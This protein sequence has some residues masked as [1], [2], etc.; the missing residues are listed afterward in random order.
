MY[1]KKD[2]VIYKCIATL[3]P[4]S[5]FGEVSLI[6]EKPRTA[7]VVTSMKLDVICMKKRNYEKVFI[8]SIER[9]H[10]KINF[11]KKY[12]PNVPINQITYFSFHFKEKFYHFKEIFYQENEK[13]DE[14]FFIIS[15]EIRI[16]K[17]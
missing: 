4:G 17:S 8:D 9:S 14:F 3:G 13:A 6:L 16:Y 11:F 12:L 10:D 15:G 5:F 1:M 2:L 7:T